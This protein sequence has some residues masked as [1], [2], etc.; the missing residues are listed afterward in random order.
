MLMFSLRKTHCRTTRSVK[1]AYF[2]FCLCRILAQNREV[3][4]DSLSP[5]LVILL[6]LRQLQKCVN[7]CQ[8]AITMPLSVTLKGAIPTTCFTKRV[9]L[10]NCQWYMTQLFQPVET[11]LPIGWNN[12][13]SCPGH[14]VGGPLLTP[15]IYGQESFFFFT[16][17]F[18]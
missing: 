2:L 13:D 11:L 17:M 9:I 4:K 6:D 18:A 15:S 12:Q 14:R 10:Q 3:H 1:V 5:L 16:K 8:F 7:L